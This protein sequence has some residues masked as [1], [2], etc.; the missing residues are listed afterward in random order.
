VGTTVRAQNFVVRDVLLESWLP[1]E[2][3]FAT[4]PGL[5]AVQPV[6]AQG[7]AGA[8]LTWLAQVS[9]DEPMH[10][11]GAVRSDAG[12]DG[13][14]SAPRDLTT[15]DVPPTSEEQLCVAQSAAGQQLASVALDFAGPP[16]ALPVVTLTIHPDATHCADQAG[17]T[18]PLVA[19]RWSISR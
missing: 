12:G 19:T 13:T 6:I 5:R 7:S 8:S 15:I 16:N 4:T 1:P 3:V 2:P 11:L 9:T 14:W 17:V 18:P 10:A